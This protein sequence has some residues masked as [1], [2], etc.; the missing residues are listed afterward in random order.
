MTI[1]TEALTELMVGIEP[2]DKAASRIEFKELIDKVYKPEM[3]LET[4]LT[5]LEYILAAPPFAPF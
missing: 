2:D 4:L 3:T 5:E 1:K